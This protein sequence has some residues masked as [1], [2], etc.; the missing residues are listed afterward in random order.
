MIGS[1]IINPGNLTEQ[2]LIQRLSDGFDAYGQATGWIDGETIFVAV[3][4]EKTSENFA[5]NVIES[6]TA[7]SILT[8]Y[9]DDIDLTNK[10]RLV[11]RNKVFNI[12]SIIIIGFDN[13]GWKITGSFEND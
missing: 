12:E 5:S 9:R 2:A 8:N 11:I 3:V 4:P 6:P 10:D 7:F 1:G 13:R